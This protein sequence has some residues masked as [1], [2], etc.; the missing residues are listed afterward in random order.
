[1][2]RIWYIKLSQRGYT[3]MKISQS[4]FSRLA[5]FIVYYRNKVLIKNIKQDYRKQ[6]LKQSL[7]KFDNIEAILHWYSISFKE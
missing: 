5:F 3:E 2:T 4:I 7:Q 6:N 1:M